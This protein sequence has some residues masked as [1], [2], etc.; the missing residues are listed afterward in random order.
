MR[1]DEET[2]KQ[3]NKD[4]QIGAGNSVYVGDL[5]DSV[6]EKELYDLFSS[7]GS[8]YL[9]SINKKE[10]KYSRGTNAYITFFDS[11]SVNLAISNFNF[12]LI[13][14]AQIRVMPLNKEA[15]GNRE[16]NVIVKNLPK[17]IDNQVLYDTFSRF[18][19][20][21]S[22]KVE[23]NLLGECTGVGYIQFSDPKV[24][25]VAIGLINKV[26]LNDKK[27]VASKCIPQNQRASNKEKINQI[28]TN[29]YAKNFPKSLTKEE[30]E[31]IL[32][33][34]GT[35]T[36]FY[37]P[38]TEEGELKGFVFANYSEHKE[39]IAAIEAL[40]DKHLPGQLPEEDPFYIQRAMNKTERQ[41]ELFK[42]HSSLSEPE[43]KNNIYVSN[44]PSNITEERLLKEFEG[45]GT[46]MSYKIGI[47]ERT[48]KSYAFILFKTVEEATAAIHKANGSLL[49]GDAISA[50]FFKSKRTQ[51]LEKAVQHG[52][53]FSKGKKKG[54]YH[55]SN[56]HGYDL[57]TQILSMAPSHAEKIREVG[58]G[59]DEEFA[60]KITGMIL[61]LGPE[62]VRKASCVGNVLSGYV[63]DSLEELISHKREDKR[64]A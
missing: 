62:E 29:I 28:F 19:K 1:I 8:I 5:P 55:E 26:K 52:H 27:L 63:E 64:M 61:E 51:E 47:D 17:D 42:V 60:K 49:D 9:L 3:A 10:S 14:G 56:N 32:S 57:Y 40:H 23:K 7:V 25:Q 16:G 48:S 13:H 43:K 41:E 37:A 31:S 4:G 45:L 11:V 58:F 54:N 53:I 6:T 18:G 24:A 44:L 33:Q 59:T 2:Q 22:C 46:I 36:S 50:C 20:I 15:V 21:T 39:A 38:L 12:Y 30:I 35:L 34:Y